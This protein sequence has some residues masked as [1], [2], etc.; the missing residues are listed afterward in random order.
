[1]GFESLGDYATTQVS[2]NNRAFRIA[3]D[4]VLLHVPDR[5][6]LADLAG[7]LPADRLA[8]LDLSHSRVILRIEGPD[9]EPLFARLVSLDV[10]P[11]VFLEGQFRQTEIHNISTLLY[12][13][14]RT[15]FDIYIP[16]SW[17]ASMLDYIVACAAPFSVSTFNNH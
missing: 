16:S 15:A 2:G 17:S 9:A 12:R 4:R 8:S 14:K 3:P 11:T 6:E 5:S 7:L 1:M 10:S 13:I